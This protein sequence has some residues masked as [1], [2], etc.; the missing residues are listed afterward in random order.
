MKH[1]LLALLLLSAR[2]V[3]AQDPGLNARDGLPHFFDKLRQGRSVTIAF[4]GGS[5]TEARGFTVHIV[6]WLQAAYPRTSIRGVNAGV[7]GTGSTLGAFRVKEDILPSHPDLVFVEFAVNDFGVDSLT[8]SQAMEGIVRRIRRTD[9]ETDV[10]FLY[11]INQIMIDTYKSGQQPPAVRYMERVAA[12][13]RLPS[14]NFAYDVLGLLQNGGMVFRGTAADT[15]SGPTVFSLDGTHPTPKGHQVYTN[16][17]K[18]ALTAWAALP[19]KGN[20]LPVP[21]DK[22]NLEAASIESPAA[23]TLTG[24]WKPFKENPYLHSFFGVFPQGVYTTTAADQLVLHFRG[25]YFG[26]EDLLGPSTCARLLVTIDGK[27]REVARF[28]QYCTW[29]RRNFFFIGGLGEGEH[30][31]SLKVDPTPVD[32]TAMIKQPPTGPNATLYP[33]NYFYLGDLLLPE[34]RN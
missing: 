10:C 22:D 19:S 26:A 9:P 6:D 5:I 7:G 31:L 15:T 28:D 2:G 25:P 11:S 8:V 16:T 4:L 29:Y 21:L 14:V 18:R 32:K 33:Q 3:P 1:L 30:T 34:Q 17:L 24:T 20:E 12:Y 23:A 13:Y 27:E